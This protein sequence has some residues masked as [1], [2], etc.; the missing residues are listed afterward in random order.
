VKTETGFPLADRVIQDLTFRLVSCEDA[1][2]VSA[3]LFGGLTRGEWASTTSDIDLVALLDAE[4]TGK[5]RAALDAIY[6]HIEASDPS[7]Y[8][9]LY[10]YHMPVE[11]LSHPQFRHAGGPVGLR[12][13]NRKRREFMGFPMSVYDA[14]DIRR[15]GR[16]IYGPDVTPM[17][18][19]VTLDDLKDMTRLDL[20]DAM[21]RYAEIGLPFNDD[22]C[23]NVTNTWS[24]VAW[25]CRSL[26][27]AR[28]PGFII[29][30]AQAMN[31]AK[32]TLDPRW[33]P[34]M[35]VALG[36]RFSPETITSEQLQT[37]RVSFGSFFREVAHRITEAL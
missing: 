3:I 15:F 10:V 5:R 6:D 32:D 9:W 21:T 30:K 13:G 18:P 34:L 11:S 14:Y 33:A 12:V 29:A 31:W 17:F 2:L 1:G 8:G 25:L 22:D 4:A 27:S 37:M 19:E 35:D 28:H 23:M 24:Y 7:A 36:L 16:T 20:K 26:Y